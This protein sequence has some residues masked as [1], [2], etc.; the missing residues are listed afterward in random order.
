NPA[1]A[2]NEVVRSRILNKKN[3]GSVK[4]SLDNIGV[5][6]IMNFPLGQREIQ[7]EYMSDRFSIFCL[8]SLYC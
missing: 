1:G 4:K 7:S 2:G 8:G 6:Y 5:I 3:E